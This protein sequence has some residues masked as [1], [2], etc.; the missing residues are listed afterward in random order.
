MSQQAALCRNQ[1]QAELK[2]ETK[3]VMTS[4]YFVVT[5]IKAN[6]SETLSQHF[7][8]LLQHEGLKMVEK[9]C[10]DKRQLCRDK[11]FRVNIERQENSVLIEKFIVAT[12]T[13]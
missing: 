12:N 3:I 13:T 1:D 7:T 10:H 8:T 11:K 9:L 6:D 4:N 5:L 2:L